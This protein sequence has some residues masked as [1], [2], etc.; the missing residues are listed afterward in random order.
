MHRQVDRE[1]ELEPSLAPDRRRPGRQDD[2]SPELI[3]LLR[4]D[5]SDAVTDQ[6]PVD[7]HD[8]LASSRGIV[9]WVVVSAAVW[10]VLVAVV[11]VVRL[12]G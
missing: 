9:G 4:G 11:L 6:P 8:A 2:I 5:A 3:P 1:A 12:L 7:D 10:L